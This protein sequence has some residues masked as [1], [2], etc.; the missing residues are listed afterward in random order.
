M[1][2]LFRSFIFYINFPIATRSLDCFQNK[3]EAE[4]LFHGACQGDMGIIAMKHLGSG[5]RTLSIQKAKA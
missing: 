2:K 1:K 5:L 4:K 3:E